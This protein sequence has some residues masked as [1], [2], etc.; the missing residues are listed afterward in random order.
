[1]FK[2]SNDI[3]F[4][5]LNQLSVGVIILDDKQRIIFFNQWVSEHSGILLNDV[6][7]EYIG[8]V[9]EGVSNSRLSAACEE[10]LNIG[11]PSMLS[12]TFNPK[13][14]PLYQRNYLGDEEYRI[15]QQISVKSIKTQTD[16]YLCQ[17][18]IDDVSS[19]VKKEKMLK[20]LANE[21]KIQQEKAEM[22]N[23]SKSQFLAN[24]SHEIRTPMNGVIGMTNLLLDTP[25]NEEQHNFAKTVKSSAES[26]L[27]IINDILDFSKVEA[28]MLTLEPIEFDIGMMMNEVGRSMYVHA[29]NKGVELI[30]PANPMQHQWYKADSGR[31][32]QILTNLVGNAIKFTEY[33]EVAV[34][35]T[36]KQQTALRTQVLI[37]VID[38]G[39]GLSESQ[40]AGLFERFTQADGSTT[41]KYGGT[42]L[43]LAICKH[44]VELMGGNIG[45][46]S[47]EG[48]GSIFWFTLDL[49][50]VMT[51]PHQASLAK[52]SS[53]KI[54]V[55]DKNLTNR[56][57]LAKLLSNWQI[58]HTL[59]ENSEQALINLHEA[60]ANGHP[61]SIVIV[62]MPMPSI[63]NEHFDAIHFGR[64]IKKDK[65]LVDTH[66]VVLTSQGQ[67]GD[68]EKFKEMGFSA[69]LS[70]PIDQFLLYN[71]LLHLTQITTQ[72][73][74]FITY[75]N[76][77]D[78]PQFNARVLVV[79]DNA[80]N[81]KVATGL[82]KKF[83]IKAEL[84]AN[85]QEALNALQ[86]FS[87]D[88]VF[89]DCQMPVMDGY[90]ATKRI[91][92]PQ[93]TVL[94]RNIPIIAMTANTMQGDREKC[95]AM[96]MDDFI[97]K[98]VD[99]NKLQQS[100]QQ[101]LPKHIE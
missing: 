60:K 54:L 12:N 65:S 7:Q 94:D 1:M 75:S 87:F 31:I 53:Q 56:I 38:S 48:K 72:D 32:R 71:R 46:K 52:L 9:F 55:V 13:P 44:L 24:M 40:Q 79:E 14:M 11:L 34:H 16:Q 86:N 88:L 2:L 41:R 85:G 99:P 23:R 101:W 20:K 29:N 63:N 73:Q 47:V 98:P 69:Y 78:L 82:L 42:G 19:M 58:E 62:D 25:L 26:L 36:V 6:Y 97:S 18:L 10:A 68:A 77:R 95:L 27:T 17:I 96:G 91:R 45:I 15:D 3:L 81:Q 70:K 39:I 66:L 49:A 37:E 67:R 21:N 43:G 74:E 61:Y 64:M 90:E 50:N 51:R 76:K 80:I 30:C 22:A 5:S 35:Y 83:G 33:G 59:A 100:L 8:D 93:S 89:M 57:L 28:G 84:A 92:D 4:T